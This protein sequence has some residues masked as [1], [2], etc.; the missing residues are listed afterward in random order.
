MNKILTLTDFS[1]IANNA[2]D[3]SLEFAKQRK[4]DLI[5]FHVLENSSHIIYE[6]D[7]DP[8]LFI[9][10]KRDKRSNSSLD[11]WRKKAIEYG[12]NVQFIIGTGDLIEG[13]MNLIK[14]QNID[15]LV[16]GSTGIDESDGIWGTNTQQVIK[17]VSIPVLI[18]KS[19]MRDYKI[20]NIVFAS[21]LEEEDKDV[22]LRAIDTI[23]PSKD[24]IIHL[25]SVDTSSFFSQP[26]LLMSSVLKDFE[27]IALPFN[28]DSN[29]FNDFTV[30]SGIRH[31]LNQKDPDVLIM[32]FRN[33]KSIKNYFL[34]NSALEAAGEVTCPVLILE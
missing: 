16:M 20:D 6:L 34:T 22:L 26:K 28:V 18:I 9:R 29:F 2:I 24:A 30:R 10:N 33:K 13:V 31:F 27:K 17:E 5:I 15:F 4:A 1:T 21:S 23:N 32:S 14:K 3:A 11:G 8:K 25:L 7:E 12:V 19:K